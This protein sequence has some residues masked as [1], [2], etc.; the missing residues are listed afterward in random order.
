MSS[1]V[2]EA[3][4]NAT[5]VAKGTTLKFTAT[6]KDSNGDAITDLDDITV[7]WEVS[8]DTD[9]PNTKIEADASKKNEATLTVGSNENGEEDSSDGNKKKLT[10]TVTAGGVTQTAKVEVTS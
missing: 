3:A 6:L 8:G 2:L 9:T 5:S 7:T 4:G 1:I 10:V